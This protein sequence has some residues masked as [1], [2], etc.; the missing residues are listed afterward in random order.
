MKKLTGTIAIFV[1]VLGIAGSTFAGLPAPPKRM[2]IE[3]MAGESNGFYGGGSFDGV[4]YFGQIG[5]AAK[6]YAAEQTG[7]TA[8]VG[9][10]D[11]Y[12]ARCATKVG[13]YIFAAMA[14]DTGIRR[15]DADWTNPTATVATDGYG[16][17]AGALATDGTYIYVCELSDE[18]SARDTITKYSITNAADSFTLTKVSSISLLDLDIYDG[19]FAGISY[20]D[21]K[22]Y[23]TDVSMQMTH[24]PASVYELDFDAGTIVEIGQV[25]DG[26]IY[27]T[28][29]YGDTML[30]GGLE[31]LF[32]FD[33]VDDGEGG[34]A[35]A[36]MVNYARLD[37]SH[38]IYGMG[39]MGDGVNVSGI[40]ITTHGYYISF[41]DTTLNADVNGDGIVDIGDFA[42]LGAEWLNGV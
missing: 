16:G 24:N 12:P 38:N 9:G 2:W 14:E 6:A 22:V 1:F 42:I 27:Q 8:F 29:R 17:G 37:G 19:G 13:D 11:G 30:C 10:D 41:Y 20:W 28:V 21:G 23:A 31:N 18:E 36:N 15:L 32:V 40:W 39:V 35:L 3:T 5:T 34:D 4:Y 26:Y 25:P 7:G 33:I